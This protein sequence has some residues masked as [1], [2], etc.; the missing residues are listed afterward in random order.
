MS[1]LRSLSALQMYHRS[2]REP[3]N[4]PAVVRFLLTDAPSPAPSPPAWRGWP[5]G[6]RR[7]RAARRS[8][9]PCGR[10]RSSS[11]WSTRPRRTARPST[12]PMDGLQLS[13][14][15]VHGQ[16]AVTYLRVAAP[17]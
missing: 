13:L 5:P 3:V 4:G 15:A 7:C 12:T 17:G 16:L 11:A 8:S 6:W 14:A 2:T 10:P 9:R 1:V